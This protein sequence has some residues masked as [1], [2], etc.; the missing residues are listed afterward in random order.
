MTVWMAVNMATVIAL[1]TWASQTPLDHHYEVKVCLS[2]GSNPEVFRAEQAASQIF[3][4]IDVKLDWRRD[5]RFC[6]HPSRGIN[7]TLSEQPE[8]AF[9]RGE[10]AYA[11]PYE[12]TTITVFYDRVKARGVRPLLGY[13]LVHEIA[14][15]LQGTNE[16]AKE[17]IMKSRWDEA[18]YAEMRRERLTFTNRDVT[19]IHNGLKTQSPKSAPAPGAK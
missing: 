16:H 17:G 2:P 6:A 8:P 5:P 3:A 11:L 10:L 14:H 12:Q 1:T 4:R 19:L 18:D 15:M 9:H 13:V 7:I